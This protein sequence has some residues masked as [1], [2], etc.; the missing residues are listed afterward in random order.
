MG[1]G[2]WG[3]QQRKKEAKKER[4]RETEGQT[5][6]KESEQ[7]INGGKRQKGERPGETQTWRGRQE[8]R[9]K[10]GRRP[11]AW[12]KGLEYASS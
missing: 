7:G 5:E 1:G 3:E 11:P 2:G 9:G 12:R 6:I 8:K 4:E 10:K